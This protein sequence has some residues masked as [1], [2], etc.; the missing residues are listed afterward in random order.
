MDA[1]AIP[2]AGDPWAATP[3][4]SHRAILMC[5]TMFA[6]LPLATDIILVALPDIAAEYGRGLSGGHQ[7]MSAFVLGVA[8]AHLLIGG[9]SDR[10]GRKP[11]AIAGFVLFTLASVVAAIST[12]FEM[13]VT[14]RALQGLAGATGPVLMRS[15]VRDLS[16]KGG[17]QRSMATIA[18]IS[19]IAP[20]LAPVIAAAIVGTLG[21]RGTF[22]FLSVFGAAT[23][24]AL[25]LLLSE[26]HPP[27]A[28]AQKLRFLSVSV[29]RALLRDRPFLLGSL[30]LAVGYGCLFTW[31]TAAGFIVTTQLGGTRTDLAVLYTLGSV[32]YILGGAVSIRLPE[33]WNRIRTGALIS[34]SG[35]ALC[36]GVFA[37]SP[38]SFWWL[39]PIALYYSGWA[40]MQPLAIAAA[41]RNHAE[42][43]GQASAVAGAIQLAGGLVLSSAAIAL[44]GGLIVLGLI[45][46][47]LLAL[48]F[49]LSQCRDGEAYHLV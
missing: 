17:G 13:L 46:A 35:T 37:G 48:L 27:L 43:A 47:T 25:V 38:G 20:L 28:R 8:V 29:V 10:Y 4:L 1:K 19:G 7:V 30:V 21:W 44:G 36:V 24:L 15:I 22:T 12:S 14:M 33:K 42:H 23:T 39:V 9:L 6:V 34:L 11:V 49:V 18:A 2:L 31:L 41:M 45:A 3:V 5:A 26:S 40:I 32:G 16:A